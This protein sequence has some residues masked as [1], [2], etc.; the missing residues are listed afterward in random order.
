VL[1]V[2]FVVCLL[3]GSLGPPGHEAEG[4]KADDV[5]HRNA[6]GEITDLGYLDSEKRIPRTQRAVLFGGHRNGNSTNARRASFRVVG[7]TA[8]TGAGR[9]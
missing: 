6:R 3:H 1:I 9:A 2:V 8:R 5:M 7:R 4:Q